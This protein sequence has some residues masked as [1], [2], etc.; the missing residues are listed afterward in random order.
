MQTITWVVCFAEYVTLMVEVTEMNAPHVIHPNAVYDRE[1][2]AIALGL[3]KSTLIREISLGR[4]RCSK[5]GGRYFIIGQ[6]LLDWIAAAELK[7]KQQEFSFRLYDPQDSSACPCEDP[8]VHSQST[9]PSSQNGEQLSN[10]ACA[11]LTGEEQKSLTDAETQEA[12]RLEYIRQLR[13]RS[14]PG[15]GEGEQLF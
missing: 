11:I 7:S 2:A 14:C 8:D 12:Y 6:W 3:P 10:S 9:E 1:A 15:C 13:Q 5:R 4:L